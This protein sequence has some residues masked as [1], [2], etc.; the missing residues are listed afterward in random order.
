MNLRPALIVALCAYV[1]VQCTKDSTVAAPE[2]IDNLDKALTQKL[3]DAAPNGKYSHFLLA[4]ER[5]LAYL[6]NQDRRNPVTIEKVQLGKFLFFETGLAQDAKD[7][8]CYQTYSCSTCH[9]P[10]S[11]F[12][13]GRFQG[14]ADGAH[15][16]GFQG[17]SR[18]AL[19]SYLEEDLDAQGLRPLTT[20]NVAYM[21]NTLWS[22][23]FG[24]DHVNEGTEEHWKGELAEVN[25]LGF[26]GLESQ[27]IEGVHLH[28]MSVNDHVLDDFGY[29]ELFDAAFPEI[30]ST[31]RY[32][33][34]T[35]SFALG[36]YL[37]TLITSEAPFQNWI[38]GDRQA[39]SD[40]QK[41][42]AMLFFGKARCYKCHNSPALSSMNFHALGTRDL[43][44][45]GGLNTHADDPRNLGRGAF[46][47]DPDDYYRFKVPQLYNLKDYVTFFHGS[48]KESLEEV[49]DFK[50]KAQSE[51]EQVP[52]DQLSTT[53]QPL[54]L[55][56]EERSELLDFLSQGLHDPNVNRYV[57]DRLPSGL[58]FPN[59]DK[60]SKQDLGCE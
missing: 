36:A 38:R 26:T 55:S 31:E 57:P 41:K 28:R 46:T 1:F 14:V 20:L 24:A 40:D 37:R 45:R 32:S 13:P 29:R 22:G 19:D 59:N 58:C 6:P 60:L 43:Y 15:G 21:T 54:E 9:V 35:I 3:I 23:L 33:A 5:D 44:E 17:S 11:G 30:D 18:K 48:S 49:L 39:L 34:Q 2:V 50:I 51:N 42:G 8:T 56:V 27:N 4:N 53:F 16:F 25:H 10:E 7:S 52:Q 12:L 47:G